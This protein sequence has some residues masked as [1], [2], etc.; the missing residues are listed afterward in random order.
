MNAKKAVYVGR[1]NPIHKGHMRTIELMLSWHGMDNS[2]VL[3]GSSNAPFSLHN[4]FT[5]AEREDWLHLLFPGI[6][7]V[8]IPDYPGDDIQWLRHMDQIL[9]LG[10]I[11]PAAA[12]Y[13]GGQPED[14]QIYESLDRETALVDRYDPDV[15]EI[16]A[17]KVRTFLAQHRYEE[18]RPLVDE[19][20]F[21]QLVSLFQKEK[22]PRLI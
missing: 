11:V 9:Q 1:L 13:Y 3:I 18:L 20:I 22:W 16:S 7:S 12:I 5:Y 8:G 14:I 4:P 15:P 21:N 6:R 17:S 2:V 10:G 19:R